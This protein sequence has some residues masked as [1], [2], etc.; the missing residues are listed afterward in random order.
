MVLINM[1]S[2]EDNVP[3][4]FRIRGNHTFA[5]RTHP[6]E[7]TH[8]ETLAS[9]QGLL[10]TSRK[11]QRLAWERWPRNGDQGQCTPISVLI[12]E[13]GRDRSRE[14]RSLPSYI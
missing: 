11:L 9:P 6:V 3:K 2:Y 1:V 12:L 13:S 7:N 8:T 14:L 4:M 10:Q 5:L